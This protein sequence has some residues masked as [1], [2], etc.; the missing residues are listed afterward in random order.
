MSNKVVAAGR[1]VLRK[2]V[3]PYTVIIA[4][5]YSPCLTHTAWVSIPANT[6]KA[7]RATVAC[8]TAYKEFVKLVSNSEH[9]DQSVVEEYPLIGCYEKH[10][11]HIEPDKDWWL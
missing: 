6:P 9:V 11:V 10:L 4:D 7:L 8:N 1:A 3:L 2:K 5:Y